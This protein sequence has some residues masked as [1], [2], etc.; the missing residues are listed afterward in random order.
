MLN[1]CAKYISD[2]PTLNRVNVKNS[3]FN[4]LRLKCGHYRLQTDL[5]YA[6]DLDMW[7]ESR[8]ALRGKGED[9]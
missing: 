6:L 3:S 2:K 8:L 1:L 5:F 7:A 9:L 4:R